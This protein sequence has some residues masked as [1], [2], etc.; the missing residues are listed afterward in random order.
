MFLQQQVLITTFFALAGIKI[1]NTFKK[2][3]TDEH[4]LLLFGVV[5]VV[6]VVVVWSM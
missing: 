6:V 3:E 5:V 1:K 4:V 2:L